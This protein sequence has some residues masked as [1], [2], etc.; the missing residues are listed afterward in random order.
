MNNQRKITWRNIVIG[1]VD[2]VGAEMSRVYGKWEPSNSP[3]T[4][5]FVREVEKSGNIRVQV[6][7]DAGTIECVVTDI[8]EGQIDFRMQ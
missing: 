1:T 6:E 3:L 2:I 8:S 7:S 4:D 5:E